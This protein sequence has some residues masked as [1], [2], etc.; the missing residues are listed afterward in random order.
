MQGEQLHDLCR[1]DTLAPVEIVEIL[2]RR[3][4][5]YRDL[6]ADARQPIRK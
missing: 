3:A 5:D 4:A 1:G 2:V 6:A